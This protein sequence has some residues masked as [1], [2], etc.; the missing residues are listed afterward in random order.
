MHQPS[1]KFDPMTGQPIQPQ[2]MH[3]PSG[4]FDP[5]TGQPIPKFD[6][7]TGKLPWYDAGEVR[8]SDAMRPGRAGAGRRGTRRRDTYNV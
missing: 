1:G 5:M 6:P 4:K 2:V 8:A 7:L 3:Q